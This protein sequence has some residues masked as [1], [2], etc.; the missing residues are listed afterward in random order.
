MQKFKDF[1]SAAFGEFLWLVIL[2]PVLTISWLGF[3]TIARDIGIPPVFAAGL[4]AA[5][6]GI[7]MFAARIGLKHRRK[8][9]S[10]WLARVVVVLFAALGSFVQSFHA[11][12]HAWIVAHSWII[13]AVAPV[14]AVLAYEL[15]LGWVHRKQ[16][17]KRGYVHPSAKSGFGPATWFLLGGTFHEYRETLR[18]RRAFIVATNLRRFQLEDAEQPQLAGLVH[19]GGPVPADFSS[20]QARLE[21]A[22]A[23]YEDVVA[24]DPSRVQ[25]PDHRATVESVQ[26]DPAPAPVFVPLAAV[27]APNP[28]IDPVLDPV[29]DSDD[30]GTPQPA[31]KPP[32]VTP[33]RKRQPEHRP[34]PVQEPLRRAAERRPAS[35]PRTRTRPASRP[36]A[37]SSPR[38]GQRRAASSSSPNAA[39]RDWC[40]EHGYKLGYNNRIPIDGLRAYRRAHQ[41]QGRAS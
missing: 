30:P 8:G 28:V 17:I 10:G 25:E 33:L 37:S 15:H 36:A 32:V 19:E 3:Y 4:S 39:V 7:A 31:P 24:T 6:D 2:T 11:Q 14:A 38:S 12:T 1:I 27:T 13:W 16:L 9:F 18:A 21:V 23:W 35:K 20:P 29:L 34:E 40:V 26:L 22:R 5:F 41:V